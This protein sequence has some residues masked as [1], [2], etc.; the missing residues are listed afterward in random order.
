[1]SES[2][3]ATPSGVDIARNFVEEYTTSLPDPTRLEWGEVKELYRSAD[4]IEQ[5]TFFVKGYAASC[6][7]FS[8]GDASL[9]KFAKELGHSY[10]GVRDQ[11]RVYLRLT[12]LKND[13][14]VSILSCVKAGALTHNHL[15][16]A[17]PLLDDDEYAEVLMKAHDNGWGYRKLAEVVAL[18][19]ALNVAEGE[20]PAEIKSNEGFVPGETDPKPQEEQNP[21]D[22]VPV[23]QIFAD[24]PPA[25]GEEP[26]PG[27]PKTSD[28]EKRFYKIN[29]WMVGLTRLDPQD[30]ASFARDVEAMERSIRGAKGVIAW[31]E[32]YAEVLEGMKQAPLRAV[33]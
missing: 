9:E 1:M 3:S 25:E 11:R 20:S 17:N 14:R 28:E 29:E 12:N 33:E 19:R 8:Y 2:N 10:S 22:K 16:K 26:W 13:V 4:T 23:G 6:A 31:F 5:A 18:K 15:L 21:L 27:P 24:L 30:V 32:T 7:I